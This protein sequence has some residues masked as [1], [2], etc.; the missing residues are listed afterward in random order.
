MD[1]VA[2]C[3]AFVSV[4]RRGS[5]TYGAAECGIPQSVASKRI[6]SLEDHLGG[7]LLD[8]TTRRV[9][10]TELGR[11]LL[12]SASAIVSLAEGLRDQARR[13]LHRPVTLMMP[14]ALAV[15]DL[16]QIAIAA[17]KHDFALRIETAE[18]AVRGEMVRVGQAEYAVQPVPAA[19]AVWQVNLGVASAQTTGDSQFQLES[20]RVR[21][22]EMKRPTRK[23]WIQTEDNV[24]HIR[25]RITWLANSISLQPG[26]LKVADTLIEAVVGVAGSKD[27]LLC[28]ER[29]AD[30]LQL[31]WRPIRELHLVRGYA[32]ASRTGE[33][34]AELLDGSASP[35]ACALGG[36]II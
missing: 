10:L 19:D 3:E 12:P 11:T 7:Q 26:Q 24:P 30:H 27:L 35:I 23:L 34:D 17:R 6:A 36:R 28:S 8:R 5:F 18:P 13:Q 21:R 33:R 9:E 16:S 25:D 14:T 1:I 20:I 32:L 2:G 4:S 15:A 29:E 22:G 31:H